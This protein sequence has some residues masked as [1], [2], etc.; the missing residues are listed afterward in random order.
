MLWTYASPAT[1]LRQLDP[2]LF[3]WS[4]ARWGPCGTW[5]HRSSPLRGTRPGPRGNAGVHLG[6]EARSGAEKHMAAPKLSSRGG[7]ARSHGTRGSAGT[8]LDRGVRS[9]AEERVAALELNSVRR[10]GPGPR[11]TWEHRS[12][13]QQG[14]EARGRETRDGF[15]AHLCREVWFEATTYV[16]ARGWTHYSLS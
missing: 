1:C 5:Q 15:G 11:A 3:L 8:H 13:P 16:V 4:T 6:R 14:G 10:W 2:S 12:S 9:G 7:R